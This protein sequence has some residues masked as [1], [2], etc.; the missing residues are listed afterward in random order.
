MTINYVTKETY[1]AIIAK[2]DEA[3][4]LR[5]KAK[6]KNLNLAMKL[7]LLRQAKAAEADMYALAGA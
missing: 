7:D 5:A 6:D 2:Q 3:R 4:R 1:D